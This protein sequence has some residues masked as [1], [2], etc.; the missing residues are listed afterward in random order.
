MGLPKRAKL[1]AIV[2]D[3]INDREGFDDPSMKQETAATIASYK[4]LLKSL[5]N[6]AGPLNEENKE[7]LR[8]AC[9]HARIWRESY[10]ESWEN[11]NDKQVINS[12]KQDIKVIDKTEDALGGKYRNH[13]Q[14]ALE[15]SES[16]SI[17]DLLKN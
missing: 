16:V 15:N 14:E 12:I 3:A 5:G 6:Q 13:F 8:K 1:R 9:F 11:T 4:V 17:W 10:L 2:E 7:I